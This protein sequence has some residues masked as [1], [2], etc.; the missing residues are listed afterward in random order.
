[1]PID[2]NPVAG[3]NLV[4]TLR[5]VDAVVQAVPKG[6]GTHV[7]HFATCPNAGAHRK[8]KAHA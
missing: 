7:S 5:A 8:G 2:P 3:G 4:L 6:Q 1:M